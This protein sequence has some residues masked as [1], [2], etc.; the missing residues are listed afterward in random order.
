MT[1]GSG[2]LTLYIPYKDSGTVFISVHA[3]ENNTIFSLSVEIE[4]MATIIRKSKVCI[5][6]PCV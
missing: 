6:Q 4:N 3:K 5:V 2:I 1:G